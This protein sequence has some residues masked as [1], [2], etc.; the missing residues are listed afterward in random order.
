MTC[1]N[2]QGYVFGRI[3]GRDGVDRD[4]G[5]EEVHMKKVTC[6]HEKYKGKKVKCEWS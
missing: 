4:R 3:D 5:E 2:R 1:V 6:Q